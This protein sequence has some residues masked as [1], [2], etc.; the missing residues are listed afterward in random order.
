MQA[1]TPYQLLLKGLVAL[2][3]S[4]DE[5]RA[6]LFIKYLNELKLWND[7]FNLTAIVDDREVVVK[8]F[9]DSVAAL[10]KFNIPTGC[11]VVDIGAGAGFPGIPI[12]II[13]PDIELF[14]VESSKKKAGFLEHIARELDLKG[15]RV[16]PERAEDFGQKKENRENSCIAVSRAVADLTV[17]AEYSL[18]LVKIGG[19]FLAYKAKDVQEEATRAERAI[20]LLGG[21]IEEIAE[22]VVPFL[23]AER[24]LVSV[25]KASPSPRI[26]PRKAGMPSR[27]PLV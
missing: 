2:G 17:L 26:Y 23:N 6:R 22:V 11:T 24:Y 21:Y 7:R 15:T 25:V 8:H 5:S 10:N 13:R 27:K 20:K 16:F 4:V 19:R 12:K 14:L 1:E 3:L 18:P 9:L